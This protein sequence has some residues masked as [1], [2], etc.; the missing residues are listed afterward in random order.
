MTYPYEQTGIS[1]LTNVLFYLFNYLTA[2]LS[3]MLGILVSVLVTYLITRLIYNTKLKDYAI[4]RTIGANKTVIIRFIYF[5]NILTTT[6]SFL[7]F[8][9]VAIYLNLTATEFAPAS[10]IF[11]SFHFYGVIHYLA[12]FGTLLL[13]ALLNSRKYCRRIFK[14]SVSKTLKSAE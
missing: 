14:E 11:Y 13:I 8:L 4:F 5:E 2:T 1:A 3:L 7:T 9:P 6:A 12:L 10:G